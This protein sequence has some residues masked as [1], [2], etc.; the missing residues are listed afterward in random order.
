LADSQALGDPQ[1]ASYR[2]DFVLAASGQD[3]ATGTYLVS[4]ADT[5]GFGLM[6]VPCGAATNAVAV[7][8]VTG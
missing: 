5:P 6:E 2:H 4:A 8:T 1:T 7:F 3:A